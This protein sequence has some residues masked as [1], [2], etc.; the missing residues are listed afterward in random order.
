M[1][2]DAVSSG[3]CCIEKIL[4][5]IGGTDEVVNLKKKK[6]KEEKRKE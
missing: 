4:L 5:G 6:K 2:S 1:E 3:F